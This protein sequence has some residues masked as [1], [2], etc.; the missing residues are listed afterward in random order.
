MTRRRAAESSVQ[1]TDG[2][3][4]QQLHPED[5]VRDPHENAQM[6]RHVDPQDPRTWVSGVDIPLS[7][8]LS[9]LTDKQLATAIVHHKLIFQLPREWWKNAKTGAYE[10]CTAVATSAEKLAKRWYVNCTIVKPSLGKRHAQVLQ[11]PVSS[12]KGVHK[13]HIQKFL[14]M[15]YNN[16]QT[17]G[18]LGLTE[19]PGEPGVTAFMAAFM[20]AAQSES[21]AAR[22]ALTPEDGLGDIGVLEPDPKTYRRALQHP[23]L[24]P[25]WR[26]SAGE[27]MEGLWKRGCFKKHYIRDLTP[28]QRKNIYGSRFHHKIKRHAKT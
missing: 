16:P 1:E 23:R 10:P 20:A 25:F 5:L 17:L 18:D 11:F 22:R 6:R 8:S 13:L 27:E 24:A 3:A 7:V 26:E 9:V 14:N 4:P 19:L 12:C 2:D 28:A 21:S 15:R